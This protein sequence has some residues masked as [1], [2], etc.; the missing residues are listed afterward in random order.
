MA[1]WCYAMIDNHLLELF[2]NDLEPVQIVLC[3]ILPQDLQ[4][5]SFISWFKAFKDFLYLYNHMAYLDTGLHSHDI[6]RY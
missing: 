1:I 5:V 4:N 3:D 2:L 6:V